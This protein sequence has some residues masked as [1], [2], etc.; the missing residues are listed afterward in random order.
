[1]PCHTCGSAGSYAATACTWAGSRGH[2]AGASLSR[3]ASTKRRLRRSRRARPNIWRLSIL[4]RLIWPST[5]P[6]DQ[7]RGHPSFDRLIVLIQ[8]LGKALHSLQG[9]AGG[10]LQP[11]I[12]VLRLALTDERSKV[13]REVDGLAH[14]GLLRAQLG[15]LLRLASVRFLVNALKCEQ[16]LPSNMSTRPQS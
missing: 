1:M 6:V 4:R 5:G 11:G 16:L 3:G 7:G 2:A 10:A 15:K 12:E 13:L 9:T 14:L 8:P